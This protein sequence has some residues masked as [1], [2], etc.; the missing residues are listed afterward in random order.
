MSLPLDGVRIVAFSQFGA[1]P[2]GMLQLADLGA[3]ILKIEDPSTGGDVARSVPPFRK[4]HDSL[5]FQAFNRNTRSITLNLRVPEARAVLH[6]LVKVSD[7]IFS[8]LRGDQPEKLGLT[9]PQLE[10]VN[11]RI[12]CCS[13]SGYGMTGPRRAEP[14]YDYLFQAAAGYMS[15]TG[16]PS[17]PPAKSGISIIDM[18]GGFAAALGLMVAVFQAQR[19]GRGSDVDVSLMDTAISMLSYLA[20]FN[21]NGN[22]EPPRL[23]D[24]AHPTLYPSQVFQTR[25]SYIVVTVMKEKFW[26]LLC[27]A[28][29][30]PDLVAE[31][32]F[33][34]FDAR[35]RNHEELIAILKDIFRTRPTHEWIERLIGQ[36]PC[37]PVNSIEQALHDPQVLAR[38]MVVETE[39]QTF[40]RMRHVAG[41]I[42]IPGHDRHVHA[43]A[44]ELGADTDAVLRDYLSYSPGQ[45]DRLRARGAV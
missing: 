40:G 33:A 45:I 20:T 6:D 34:D 25:D 32:R 9:Y 5:Y 43:A 38:N 10:H 23:P 1:G 42:K 14:G 18:A 4:G 24:S 12:V 13:L 29:E 11:P 31:P 19:T 22:Y 37:A 36:V 15:L 7:A 17:T 21:L 16:D 28:L 2:F 27:D 3:E 26:P 41:A 44:P 39:N 8:N 30:R 35:Y